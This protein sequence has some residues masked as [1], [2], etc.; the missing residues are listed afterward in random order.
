[1]K[2]RTLFT[3]GVVAGAV[4]AARSSQAQFFTAPFGPGGTWNL[5]E[6]TN[7]AVNTT[8]S[9]ATWKA[10][11][12][13]AIAKTAASTGVSGS[14]RQRDHRAP[15]RDRKLAGKRDGV[16]D[17]APP[18]QQFQRVD[19]PLRQRRCGSWRSGLGGSPSRDKTSDQ[20]FWAGTRR[21]AQGPAR[22]AGPSLTREAITRPLAPVNPMALP[23][24]VSRCGRTGG[25][26]T[27]LTILPPRCAALHRVGDCVRDPDRGSHRAESLFHR[28]VRDRAGHGIFTRSSAKRTPGT[29]LTPGPSR[30]KLKPPALPGSQAAPPK[31]ICSRFPPALRIRSAR[32][33]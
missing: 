11:H 9:T 1:M 2:T 3:A 31:G 26:T 24:T 30:S 15:R 27:L 23:K 13:A 16:A 12:Q 28:P 22:T 33:S 19:R 14:G 18:H 5:Y 8:P 32:R 7:N 4:L 21:V 10:A 20:W 17:G 29:P 25:G 6:I